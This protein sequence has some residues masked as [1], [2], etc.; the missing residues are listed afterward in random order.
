MLSLGEVAEA[1][2][3]HERALAIGEKV[4]G[5]EH[6]HLFG[7]LNDF[8]RLLQDLGEPE[9]A[10]PL[11]ERY[12]RFL[13][14]SPGHGGLVPFW[15]LHPW[16]S[17]LLDLGDL[18][19]AQYHLE[20]ALSGAPAYE[21]GLGDWQGPDYEG[22]VA[23][24]PTLGRLRRLQG[25]LEEAKACLQQSLATPE[26]PGLPRPGRMAATHL[27]YGLTLQALG[28]LAGAREHLAQAVTIFERQLGPKH[29]RTERA[30][31]ELAALDAEAA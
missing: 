9:S 7:T 14:E 12:V 11:V 1:R 2:A 18:E 19:G 20:R 10:K 16:A 17:V 8:A 28:D 31:R 5:P 21:G 27:E 15:A 26:Y 4:Y 24:L 3:Y 22:A 30:R 29:P 13:E 25:R 6:G 23:L